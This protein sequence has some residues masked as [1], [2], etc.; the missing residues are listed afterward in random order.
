ML[1]PLFYS[2]RVVCAVIFMV[3]A[4]QASS[5][6]NLNAK[7]L[8][9]V[10]DSYP[11]ESQDGRRVVF[12]SNRT[13]NWEIYTMN[14]DGSSIKQLTHHEGAD[15]TPHW[16]PDGRKI[17]FVSERDG[18]QAG[19]EIYI[20][21]DDGTQQK[22]LTNQPGDDSNPKFTPDGQN[23]V[24]NSARTTPDLT[25]DWTEQWHE[26][27]MMDTEGRNVRQ[28]TT[29]KTIC[30]FPAVS[31]DGKKIAYRKVID[32]PALNWDISVNKN[33]RN[34]EIF[35][36]DIDGSND[37]NVSNSPAFDG[38]PSWSPDSRSLVFAS[39]RRGPANVGQIFIVDPQGKVIMQL[40]SGDVGFVQPSFSAGSK[41]LYA[42]QVWETN[43]YEYGNIVSFDLVAPREG[44]PPTA[45]MIAAKAK[46]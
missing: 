23:I 40:T 41:K 34:S 44:Y 7:R 2:T 14:A 5:Q 31:P 22:R 29:H 45:W 6:Q 4:F 3:I 10:S 36:M 26:L 16:S 17:V 11:V 24:F 27:F 38:W 42:Y 20:M 35:T 37:V 1:P 8:T 46:K 9:N 33:N 21:N 43:E 28:L 15:N 18:K 32:G 39:N 13:G 12:Q 30:T 25:V 19:S